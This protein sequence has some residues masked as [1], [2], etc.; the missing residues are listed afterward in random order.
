MYLIIVLFD[1]VNYFIKVTVQKVRNCTEDWSDRKLSLEG[2]TTLIK[3][4]IYGLLNHTMK[5]KRFSEENCR[6]IDKARDNF[7]W[8]GPR[9]LEP[10]LLAREKRFGC[11][12]LPRAMYK[13]KAMLA[14]WISHLR[15]G[16]EIVRFPSK[17]HFCSFLVLRPFVHPLS[18]QR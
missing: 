4:K 6:A 12:S 5:H 11:F 16:N 9:L 15:R 7:L 2:K 1:L 3:S 14:Q 8:K 18:W 13:N 17:L 10:R